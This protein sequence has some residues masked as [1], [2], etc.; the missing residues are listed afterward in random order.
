MAQDDDSTERIK[1]HPDVPTTG[2]AIARTHSDATAIARRIAGDK[3]PNECRFRCITCGWD[4]TLK[5]EEDEIEALAGDITQYGGPCG[6]CNSMTLV[7]YSTLF[8]A[9]FKP[10]LERDRE[11]RHKE[12]KEQAEV[13]AEVLVKT[14][15]KVVREG[16][17]LDASAE[18]P[19]ADDEP[20]VLDPEDVE[21]LT[22]RKG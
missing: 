5:F 15:Q 1:I 14:V 21:G 10:V 7:P 4:K 13:Q 20:P 18:A 22:P 12:Y 17:V 8:G 9:E 3:V 19:P 6:E 16:S 2:T 11:A